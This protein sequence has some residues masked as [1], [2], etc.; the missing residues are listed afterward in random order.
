MSVSVIVTTFDAGSPVCAQLLAISTLASGIVLTSPNPAN[1]TSQ[2]SYY[3]GETFQS[4][5]QPSFNV[6]SILASDAS[7]LYALGWA[8]TSLGQSVMAYLDNLNTVA[9]KEVY[10][11][12]V[13]YFSRVS[14]WTYVSSQQRVYASCMLSSSVTFA[15][16]VPT[17]LSFSGL[18][19]D[20]VIEINSWEILQS[21]PIT[22]I[23]QTALTH[24]IFV[25]GRFELT[26]E[27]L[28]NGPKFTLS[29]NY[30]DIA[31]WDGSKSWK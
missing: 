2:L 24:T 9:W 11:H 19:D 7:G 30:Y 15:E 5:A 21:A 16:E 6:T 13:S 18:G 14:S 22:A 3:N 26:Q 8:Q 27:D 31:Q 25:G 29:R 1:C 28:D 23:T 20:V 17:V 10:L 4:L 12:D